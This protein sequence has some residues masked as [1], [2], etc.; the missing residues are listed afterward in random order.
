MWSRYLNFRNTLASLALAAAVLT[1]FAKQYPYFPVDLI[2]T[3]FIQSIPGLWFRDLMVVISWAGNYPQSLVVIGLVSLVVFW[4]L[5]KKSSAM[6]IIST[7]G[8]V[9]VS[10]LFK[11]LVGRIRPDQ[12]TYD[13]FPSGHVLFYIGLMGFLTYLIYTNLPKG[14][15]RSTLIF[16]LVL[17]IIL[18][19][20]S[21]IYLGFH[22]FSDVLGASLLGLL[23]LLVVVKIFKHAQPVSPQKTSLR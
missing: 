10:I 16:T 14:V 20:V 13:S 22:W 23:W 5:G 18:S 7:I 4:R 15:L 1:F 6:V 9:I 17:L 21:R 19:G 2:V 11:S 12:T 8:A 3:S